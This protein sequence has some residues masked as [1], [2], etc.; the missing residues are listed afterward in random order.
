MTEKEEESYNIIYNNGEKLGNGMTKPTNKI[1]EDIFVL[2]N[3]E[4]N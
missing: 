3:G 2:C 1:L 4:I